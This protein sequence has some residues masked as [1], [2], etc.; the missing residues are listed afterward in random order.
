M[1][2]SAQMTGDIPGEASPEAC[3]PDPCPAPDRCAASAARSGPH[4]PN[5]LHAVFTAIS[6][7]LRG[8]TFCLPQYLVAVLLPALD[9]PLLV[10]ASE[11]AMVAPGVAAVGRA[12]PRTA[13]LVRARSRGRGLG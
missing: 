13:V 1:V 2:R 11:K 12:G 6:Q 9:A 3:L 8:T 4:S 5:S 7:C 10:L